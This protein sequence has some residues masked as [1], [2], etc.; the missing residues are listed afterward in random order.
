MR[1]GAQL[2]VTIRTHT[3]YALNG[4]CKSHECCRVLGHS[5]EDNKVKW[6]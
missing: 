3:K 4:K 2:S 1:N 5:N 6:V